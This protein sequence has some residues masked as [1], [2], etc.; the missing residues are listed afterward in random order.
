MPPQFLQS[1]LGQPARP[2]EPLPP[3]SAM[4]AEAVVPELAYTPTT[5][6]Q[7]ERA[8]S[9]MA[10]WLS[11]SLKGALVDVTADSGAAIR[12][13]KQEYAFAPKPEVQPLL[14]G[15]AQGIRKLDVGVAYCLGSEV[16]KAITSALPHGTMSLSLAPTLSIQVI[17]T[18]AG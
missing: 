14:A 12:I 5:L 15:F 10:S 1:A 9:V 13:S 17:E 7:S 11:F 8:C 6:I 3:Q 18:M 4:L 2:V 16:V